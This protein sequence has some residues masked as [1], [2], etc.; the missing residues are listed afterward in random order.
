[1]NWS[2]LHRKRID[3][4]KFVCLL[5]SRCV[6]GLV[7]PDDLSDLVSQGILV[8]ALRVVQPD[9]RVRHPTEGHHTHSCAVG[10]EQSKSG[11]T[12]H[13]CVRLKFVSHSTFLA[14]SLCASESLF[15]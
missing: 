3:L 4:C 6:G 14:E 15:I 7:L 9:L 5:T 2:V 1:M 12:T 11:N 10:K 13:Q 8:P